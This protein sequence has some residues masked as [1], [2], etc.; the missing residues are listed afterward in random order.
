M[1]GHSDS[2]R[3]R[4]NAVVQSANLSEDVDMRARRVFCNAVLGAMVRLQDVDNR[5]SST[6]EVTFANRL[7]VLPYVFSDGAQ[8]C[9][10]VQ[11]R[12]N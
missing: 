7:E 10:H 1:L 11:V 4:A 5:P 3:I 2:E 9:N 8:F 6:R 12:H